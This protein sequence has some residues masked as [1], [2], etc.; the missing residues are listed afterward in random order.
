MKTKP[1]LILCAIIAAAIIGGIWQH[2]NRRAADIA[3]HRAELAR[4]NAAEMV[5]FKAKLA[6]GSTAAPAPL[7]PAQMGMKEGLEKIQAANAT[8]QALRDEPGL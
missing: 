7:T 4:R 8:L 6:A 3:A 2:S 1:L 5:A